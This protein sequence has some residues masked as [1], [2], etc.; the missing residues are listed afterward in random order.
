V[1]GGNGLT[2]MRERAASCG[3]VLTIGMSPLGGW[4]VTAV[5]RSTLPSLSAWG[6]GFGSADAPASTLETFETSPG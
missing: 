4:L 3:G 1:L 5:L 2:G 6:S